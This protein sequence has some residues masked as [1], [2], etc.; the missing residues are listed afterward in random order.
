MEDNNNTTT[1]PPQN[2]NIDSIIESNSFDAI[3]DHFNNKLNCSD[4]E[5]ST[6]ESDYDTDDDII[7]DNYLLNKSGENIADILTNINT[8]LSKIISIFNDKQ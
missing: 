4:N 3:I 6:D 8:N 5:H 7:L 2:P 1:L